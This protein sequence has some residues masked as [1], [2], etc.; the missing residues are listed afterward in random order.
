MDKKD[1]RIVDDYIEAVERR[2]NSVLGHYAT[3]LG[4]I[5]AAVGRYEAERLASAS[6]CDVAITCGTLVENAVYTATL[7]FITNKSAER[8]TA[9]RM[10]ND[11]RASLTMSWIGVLKTDLWDYDLVYYLPVETEDRWVGVVDENIADAAATMEVE[12][13]ELPKAREARVSAVLQEIL[14][15]ET[16][17]PDEQTSR[18]SDGEGEEVRLTPGHVPDLP[19]QT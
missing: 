11:A 2:S 14:A 5:Q 13:T 12:Y 8:D 16:A 19:K 10:V 4:N 18:D 15:L 6:Q 17:L 9:Y 7:A 1:V 3:Y